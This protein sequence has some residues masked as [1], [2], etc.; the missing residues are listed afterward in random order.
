MGPLFLLACW[1]LILNSPLAVNLSPLVCQGKG[2]FTEL[3]VSTRLRSS[4]RLSSWRIEIA[5]GVTLQRKRCQH[6][7]SPRGLLLKLR[8]IVGG[9]K[10]I[11]RLKY[12]LWKE[13]HREGIEIDVE[14]SLIENRKH[15]S[16]GTRIIGYEMEQIW[17]NHQKRS[18][19]GSRIIKLCCTACICVNHADGGSTCEI[20]D[21]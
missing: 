20:W 6:G 16:L 18:W 11:C 4:H 15:C 1:I 19:C 2:Y 3:L 13:R 9:G 21:S 7:I 5:T 14:H 17:R 8:C 10:A 12:I